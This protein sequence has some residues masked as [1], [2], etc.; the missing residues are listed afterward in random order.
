MI[1]LHAPIGALVNQS[2]VNYFRGEEGEI[3]RSSLECRQTKIKTTYC[4][5]QALILSVV[6]AILIKIIVI[7]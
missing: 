4:I 1:H 5:H 2:I 3:S 6:S 7:I